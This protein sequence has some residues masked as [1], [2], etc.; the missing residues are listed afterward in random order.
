[1]PNK[2]I[3]LILN[4]ILG[5]LVFVLLVVS[6]YEQLRKQPGWLHSLKEVSRELLNGKNVWLLVLAAFM[7]VVNWTIEARKWQLAVASLQRLSLTRSLLAVFSGTALAFFTPNRV[8]EYVGRILYL[9]EGKRLEAIPVSLICSLAQMLVTFGGGIA[10]L[11]CLRRVIGGR[12]DAMMLRAWMDAILLMSVLIT[13]FLT[14]LYFRIGALPR[15][16]ARFRGLDKLRRYVHALGEVRGFILCRILLL[17]LLRYLVFMIQYYLLFRVFGV[18]LNGWQVFWSVSV[19]FLVLAV[20]PTIAILT[21]LGVRWK[22]STEVV[23]LFSSNTVGILAASMAIWI[24]NLVIPA[25]IGS[26]LLL[27][28]KIFKH[29]TNNRHSSS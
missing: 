20:I 21:D 28:I 11:I 25:L 19:I 3:K 17:S 22:A 8:G 6:I 15:L 29:R 14:L 26:L 7:M 23:M 24:I 5:P 13:I 16:L 18:I 1:M 12:G 10:G 27:R 9:D 2:S 4:Y